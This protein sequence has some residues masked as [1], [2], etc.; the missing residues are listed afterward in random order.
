MKTPT[1]WFWPKIVFYKSCTIL[2]KI[3]KTLFRNVFKSCWNLT[4]YA[5]WS[6]FWSQSPIRL[7]LKSTSNKV[8]KIFRATADLKVCVVK[9]SWCKHCSVDWKI[10]V[11]LIDFKMVTVLGIGVIPGHGGG[12]GALLE[13]PPQGWPYPPLSWGPPT[14][15]IWPT[16]FRTF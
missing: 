16:P 3:S 11:W 9:C 15:D 4:T 2:I 5:D 7:L 6:Y 1:F 12:W 13:S 10:G 8:A 14:L